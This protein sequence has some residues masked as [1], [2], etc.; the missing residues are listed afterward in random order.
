MSIDTP[1]QS[2]ASAIGAAIHRDLT[3]IVSAN[4]KAIEIYPNDVEIIMFPQGWGSTALGYGGVG[5]QSMT[6]SYT[7]IVQYYS[8]YCVYFGGSRLAYKIDYNKLSKDGQQNFWN[9]IRNHDMAS[10]RENLN[11]YY[12]KEEKKKDPDTCAV[13]P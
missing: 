10:C 11:R 2:L 4:G 1:V 8:Q 12:R 13:L 3:K 9:D 7:V 6:T 5:G